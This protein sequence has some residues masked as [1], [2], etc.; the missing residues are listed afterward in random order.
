MFIGRS[1]PIAS[2]SPRGGVVIYKHLDSSLDFEVI[3]DE[4][5]DCIIFRLL[6][7]DII[8]AAV[9]IPPSNSKYSTPEYM[10]NLQLISSNFKN[11]PTYI[12]GDLNARYGEITPNNDNAIFYA[13]N[14]DKTINTNGRVLTRL[15]NEET[16]FMIINGLRTERTQCDSDFTYFRGELCS[17]LDIVIER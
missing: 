7:V 1:K 5:R 2:A 15:L 8:C 6:P 17:Q 12:V 13:P 11:T 14:P 9:Y 4:L 16:D 3:T 10:E